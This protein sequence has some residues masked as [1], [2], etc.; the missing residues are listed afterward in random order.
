MQ[1]LAVGALLALLGSPLVGADPKVVMVLKVSGPVKM[2]NSKSF[3]PV[4]TGQMWSE[5]SKIVVP[6]GS[7]VTV[8]LLNKGQRL[9]IEGAGTLKV[10]QTGLAVEGCKSRP[11]ESTG[12][13]LALTGDN[14][15]QIGG[16]TVR[17]SKPTEISAMLDGVEIVGGDEPGVKVSRPATAAPPPTLEFSYL[18]D[19]AQPGLSADLEHVQLD[20]FMLDAGMV[21][22][23]TAE[24]RLVGKRWEWLVPWP[25]EPAPQNYALRMTNPADKSDKRQV[26]YTRV[27]STTAAEEAELNQAQREAAEWAQREPRSIEPWVLYANL[28]EEKGRLQEALEAL[29]RGLAIQP[30]E[31]GLI[32]MKAR[33]LMDLG[34]YNQASSLLKAF[35]SKR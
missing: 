26:L 35:R 28:L 6:K 8:L 7:K 32:Q 15:R 10:S 25:A 11:L 14:H 23:S 16:A 3:T 33:L 21:W 34:R 18:N 20:T 31:S 27:R 4:M 13:T 1:K 29:D 2:Q 17:G 24:G 22:K 5:G 30:R 19:Y 9:E 12:H